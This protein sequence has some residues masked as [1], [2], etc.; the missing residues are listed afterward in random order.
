MAVSPG[1][2]LKVS[3]TS[4]PSM[5]SRS[6]ACLGGAAIGVDDITIVLWPPGCGAGCGGRE[7]SWVEPPPAPEGGSNDD[8]G[9]R[10]TWAVDMSGPEDGGRSADGA[11]CVV[12][13]SGYAFMS[14]GGA[15]GA[16]TVG[17]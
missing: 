15:V 5:M 11:G 4:P 1:L 7:M 6:F 13:V 9:A 3:P 10:G 12:I 14:A 8:S 17:M 16:I 2:R